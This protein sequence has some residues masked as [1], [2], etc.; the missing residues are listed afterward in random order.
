MKNANEK[1][2][3][4]VLKELVETYRLKSNLNQS[5]IKSAWGQLMGPSIARYT[6]DI[7]VRKHTLYLTVES[8]A[9]RQEL[10]F[11]KEK[12]M[13]ILNEEL[14]EEFIREVVIR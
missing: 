13:K 4:E 10:S 8:A 7:K 14:G 11:G 1:S 9:L 2:L 6:K 5:R 3:K 12:I